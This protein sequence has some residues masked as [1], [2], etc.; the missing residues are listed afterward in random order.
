[1]A[2]RYVGTLYLFFVSIIGI[3][4]GTVYVQMLPHAIMSDLLEHWGTIFNSSVQVNPAWETLL[5]YFSY[6]IRFFVCMLVIGLTIIG[7][8]IALFIHF[9][10]AFLIGSAVQLF[11]FIWDNESYMYIIIW[12]LPS[13]L[14]I[15]AALITLSSALARYSYDYFLLIKHKNTSFPLNRLTK[16]SAITFLLIIAASC[17]HTFLSPLLYEW[18][19]SAN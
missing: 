15:I 2:S 6:H 5:A 11:L 12:L 10:K 17:T 1:M 19:M 7:Y 13:S 18:Y 4:F 3:I 8:P 14:F 9:L 16:L